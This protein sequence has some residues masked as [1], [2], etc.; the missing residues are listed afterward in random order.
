MKVC[1]MPTKIGSQ[2]NRIKMII[3]PK[4][5]IMNGWITHPDCKEYQDWVDR[6]FVSPNAIDFTLDSMSLVLPHSPCFVSEEDRKHR[7]VIANQLTNNPICASEDERLLV[8]WWEMQTQSFYDCESKMY[9][10]VPENVACR[11]VIRSTFARNGVFLNSGKYDSGFTGNVGWTLYNTLGLLYTKPG[12]RVG[13]I[14]FNQAMSEG[15]YA[16]HY[17]HDKGESWRTKHE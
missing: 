7:K 15:T 17:S 8:D 9:V 16:G 14:V 3:S 5:A 2:R 13:Q 4:D 1:I 11:L 10:T 12:T 6:K